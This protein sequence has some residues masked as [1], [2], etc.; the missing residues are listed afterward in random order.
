MYL[1][2]P[3]KLGV[4]VTREVTIDLTVEKQDVV[5]GDGEHSPWLGLLFPDPDSI[6]RRW[7]LVVV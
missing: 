7:N 1:F 6:R 4:T 3:L 5:L 2:F